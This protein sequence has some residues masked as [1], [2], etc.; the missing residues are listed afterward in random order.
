MSYHTLNPTRTQWL[1]PVGLRLK[2]AIDRNP[3][4]RV[5]VLG[6]LNGITSL[7]LL[8]PAITL[9]SA[10]LTAVWLYGHI[11]GPLD[12]FVTEVLC[13]L[14]LAAG[15]VTLQQYLTPSRQPGGVNLDEQQSP[16]LFSM[17]ERRLAHFH[18]TP[19]SRILLTEDAKLA[20]RQIPRHVLPFGYKTV[21][22]IGAPLLFF[23]S[24]DL[25]R[26]ALAGAVAAQARKQQGLR[27]WIA[28]RSEDWPQMIDALR[29]RPSLAARL[30]LPALK[31]LNAWNIALGHELRTELQQDAGRWV[32]DHVDEQQAEQ[33]LASQVLAEIYLRRQYWPMIM[34]AADR[35]PA[36]VVK[37]FSHFELLLGKTLNRENANRWLLQAQTSRNS[38]NALRDLLAGLGLERL[39]WSGLPEQPAALR[40]LTGGLLKALDQ[41]WQT[42]IQ[43]EWDEHHARFQHDLKRFEQ[44]RQ[45][46]AEQSLHGEPAMRYIQ[47]AE[48]LVDKDQ[49]AVICQS[50]CST[51][52]NDAALNFACGRQ[53][54]EAG[55]ARDG[56]E[57][58]Q[59]A[60]ELDNS[61]AHRA[62]AIINEQ[63]CAWL[64]EVSD[65]NKA[66]A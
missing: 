44:L 46:H 35:C 14:A 9:A 31:R 60:A 26:L 54:V 22:T 1:Q 64:N 11:H 49:L 57:V 18:V 19:P 43:S 24:H 33:L 62:H 56:C 16:E 58:L 42:R 32:A 12:W 63:N 34:K 10:S 20:I 27:G 29:H 48:Q 30:L 61:L 65:E 21:L 2:R 40:L 53:L 39:V 52:R 50:V 15:W 4:L 66:S 23:L 17:L 28:R 36:P 37:P 13:A 7:L 6:T 5:A 3:V 38:H 25:F 45:H 55:H 41:V 51:N 47:L 8:S 59:R